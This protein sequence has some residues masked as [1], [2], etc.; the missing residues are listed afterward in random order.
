MA[1]EP[2][3]GVH[4]GCVNWAVARWCPEDDTARG[5]MA[6]TNNPSG[7]LGPKDPYRLHQTD[8]ASKQ[9]PTHS[10][11]HPNQT[12]DTHTMSSHGFS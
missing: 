2:I 6:R 7:A 12:Q 3:I 8:V 11:T 5:S 1:L 4:E 9:P 10:L